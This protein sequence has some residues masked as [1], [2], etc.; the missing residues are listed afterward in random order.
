MLVNRKLNQAFVIVFLLATLHYKRKLL[1]KHHKCNYIHRKLQQEQESPKNQQTTSNS[2][3]CLP[4]R[5]S[6]GVV[7]LG[8]AGFL[9]SHYEQ[10]KSKN[11][12]IGLIAFSSGNSY[13]CTY[14]S[15]IIRNSQCRKDRL[16]VCLS[17]PQIKWLLECNLSR[18]LKKIS[19]LY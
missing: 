3:D 13:F 11:A 16:S 18:N 4:C 15:I 7:Q 6:G 2:V 8:I 9:A 10:M 1:A 5:I 12:R 14:I 17:K 19:P